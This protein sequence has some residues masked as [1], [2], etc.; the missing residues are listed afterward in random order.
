MMKSVQKKSETS[1]EAAQG[2]FNPS[3][4]TGEGHGWTAAAREN[5]VLNT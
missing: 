2:I 5:L 1:V 4:K 3:V